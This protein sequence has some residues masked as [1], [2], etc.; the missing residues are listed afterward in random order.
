MLISSIL[1]IDFFHLSDQ[2][3]VFYLPLKQTL[4]AR[5]QFQRITIYKPQQVHTFR[6]D[7]MDPQT[8]P[9]MLGASQRKRCREEQEEIE[10]P[11]KVRRV[12]PFIAAPLTD[13]PL[14]DSPFKD[15][16]FFSLPLE[17]RQMIY[18]QHL[19]GPIT[20]FNGSNITKI[21]LAAIRSRERRD[22]KKGCTKRF[23]TAAKLKL[24]EYC[25]AFQSLYQF[26]HQNSPL[27]PDELEWV[28][29]DILKQ[30]KTEEQRLHLELEGIVSV[31]SSEYMF[32]KWGWKCEDILFSVHKCFARY[33]RKSGMDRRQASFEAFI[34]HNVF[35]KMQ[36]KWSLYAHFAERSEEFLQV[37]ANPESIKSKWVLSPAYMLTD[38]MMDPFTWGYLAKTGTGREFMMNF[39]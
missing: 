23:R 15:A 30:L 22:S 27:G 12:S 17:I 24:E 20:S 6:R 21:L 25:Y 13:I 32:S 2:K 8:Q 33:Y 18:R 31:L 1:Q 28:I 26:V 9:A 7:T 35:Q 4:R 19:D 11:R 16:T 36:R 39:E 37:L 10:R 29:Q 5:H 38:S 3:P 14:K 34:Q